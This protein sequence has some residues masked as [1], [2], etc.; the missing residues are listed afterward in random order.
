MFP[1]HQLL[2]LAPWLVMTWGLPLDPR[3]SSNP[4]PDQ[5]RD[6]GTF[7]DQSVKFGSIGAMTGAVT[8]SVK[9]WLG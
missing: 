9:G 7:F 8:H 3:D 6:L 5:Q 1:L 2:T 4:Q